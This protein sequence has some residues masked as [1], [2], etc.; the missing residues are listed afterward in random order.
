MDLLGWDRKFKGLILSR[1]IL[2]NLKGIHIF[3]KG[4]G[5]NIYYYFKKNRKIE[6]DIN[7]VTKFYWNPLFTL[8]DF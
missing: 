1:D 8:I 6:R 5:S 4:T 7:L 2:Y 3:K